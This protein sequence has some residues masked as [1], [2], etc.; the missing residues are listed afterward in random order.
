MVLTISLSLSPEAEARL[1]AK[2]AMVGIGLE[3]YAAK[4]LERLASPPRSLEDLSG[5][6]AH[7][8]EESGMTEDELAA[9]LEQE[10]HAARA[11]RAAK[12]DEKFNAATL[13]RL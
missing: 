13:P 8:C 6:V 1:R 3:A 2:A 10:K 9:F 5:P 7:A 12:L 11:E 4:E